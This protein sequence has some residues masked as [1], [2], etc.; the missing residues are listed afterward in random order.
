MVLP[1]LGLVE[2]TTVLVDIA[3]STEQNNYPRY[4]TQDSVN[5]AVQD[6]VR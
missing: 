1:L 6:T 3:T 2:A 5:I 4:W